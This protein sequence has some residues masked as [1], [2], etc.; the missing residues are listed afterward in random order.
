MFKPY[1]IRIDCGALRGDAR[2]RISDR[3]EPLIGWAVLPDKDAVSQSA[4]RIRVSA[5]KQLLWDPGWITSS[6]QSVRYAGQP[7]PRW[8][9]IDIFLQVKDQAGRESLPAEDFF[10]FAQEEDWDAPSRFR[11]CAQRDRLFYKSV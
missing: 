7:L 2:M 6:E 9:R 1:G 4:Y 8:E 5:G 11:G 10:Y 3:T